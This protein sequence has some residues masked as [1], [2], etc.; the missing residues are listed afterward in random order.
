[1]NQDIKTFQLIIKGKVQ[2]V[3]FRYWFYQEAI[4]LGLK[5]YVRNKTNENE[6]ES[7]V[8]GKMNSILHIIEKCKKDPKFAIVK[9]VASTKIINNETYSSFIINYDT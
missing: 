3:G 2:G 5:G 8:Q 7:I 6:V 4:A 1:M 9:E